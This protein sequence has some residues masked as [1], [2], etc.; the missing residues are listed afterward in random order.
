[1]YNQH[2]FLYHRFCVAGGGGKACASRC[3]LAFHDVNVHTAAELGL[4]AAQYADLPDLPGSDFRFRGSCADGVGATELREQGLRQG[5]EDA[6]EGPGDP[7]TRSSNSSN[8]Y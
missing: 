7:G 6:R 8:Y 1:M 5:L 2:L 3:V 4:S